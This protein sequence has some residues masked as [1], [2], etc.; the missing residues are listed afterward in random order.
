[1]TLSYVIPCYR[2]EKTIA[3]VINEIEQV[4][5]QRPEYKYEIICV[6]DGSPDGVYQIL[7]EIASKN[8]RLKI[9]NFARNFGKA[10]AVLAAYGKCAGDVVVSLDDDGQCPVD[11]TWDLVDALDEEHD[12]AFAD[13]PK[14]KENFIKRI[15]SR[16]NATVMNLLVEQPDDITINN[17][18]AMKRFVADEMTHYKNPFP[19]LHPLLVQ[20]THSIVMVPMEER[21]R[22]DGR[23]SGFTFLKSVRL[24]INGFTNF[25][26][27]PL[28][29]AAGI[30]VIF[31][32]IG[33]VYA[34]IIVVRKLTYPSVL[35]GYSSI[36][37]ALFFIGGVIM[38]LLGVIGEYLGRVYICI[39]NAPQYVIRDMINIDC[40][41]EEVI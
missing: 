17:F 40:N 34:I 16:V 2:S 24:M 29:I 31:S 28:R 30:G 33:F 13:Y 9:I 36:M 6:N 32:L 25:S 27:K 23:T 26:V 21:E 5:N 20:T 11:R 19:S 8:S 39:N 7:K 35:V 1:M 38:L 15:G 18:S 10:A 12:L 37:A 3:G 41:L 4:M 22:S 14:K